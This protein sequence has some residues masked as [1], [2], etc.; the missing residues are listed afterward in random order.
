MLSRIILKSFKLTFKWPVGMT[1]GSER[2]D[3]SWKIP[4][5]LC[6]APSRILTAIFPMV[7]PAGTTTEYV[8]ATAVAEA[9]TGVV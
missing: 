1:Y 6:P 8:F 7:K 4:T 3:Q 2:E 5:R 9:R